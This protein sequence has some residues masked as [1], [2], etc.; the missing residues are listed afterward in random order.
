[1]I[2]SWAVDQEGATALIL[3]TLG[4]FLEAMFAPFSET[5]STLELPPMPANPPWEQIMD[6]DLRLGVEYPQAPAT[7]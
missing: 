7:P 5:A 1:M 6:L 4:G 3:T 2:H